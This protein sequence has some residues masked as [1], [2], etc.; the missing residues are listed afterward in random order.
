M[1]VKRVASDNK[2]NYKSPRDPKWVSRY[3]GTYENKTRAAW[4]AR[5]AARVADR[6]RIGDVTHARADGGRRAGGGRAARPPLLEGE[7]TINVARSFHRGWR[8]V[9]D[10]DHRAAIA[11]D[12]TRR[13]RRAAVPNSVRQGWQ[14]AIIVAKIIKTNYLLINIQNVNGSRFLSVLHS[15]KTRH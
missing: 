10:S 14:I 1:T 5:P 6:H 4:T 8:D 7:A 12:R 2:I 11:G 3:V 15:L 9:N 13:P